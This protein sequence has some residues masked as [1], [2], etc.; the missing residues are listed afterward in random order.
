MNSS[1]NAR[2]LFAT[3]IAA[4]TAFAQLGT[5]TTEQRLHLTQTWK[6]E[7]FED[8]RPKVPDSILKRMKQVTAEEAWSVLNSA[9]FRDHF[10]RGWETVNDSED[11]LVGRVVTA[12]FLPV[13]PDVNAVINETAAQEGRVSKGQ[14][15]W[16]IDTLVPGDVLVVDL[17]GKYNFM[18]DNLATA[19]FTKSKNGVIINGGARDLSGIREIEGFNAYVRGWHPS[20][21]T[22]GVRN[23]MLMGI[24]VPIRIGET[25]VMPGDIVLSDPEGL[26]FIPPQLAE[27]VVTTSEDIRLR[28][29]WGHQMLREGKYTPGQ[30][31]TKWTRQMEEEFRRWADSR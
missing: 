26:M 18:G 5:F 24:N 8:G 1:Q 3:L 31:D 11:R 21:V 14:N 6:G 13:R 23:T 10:E 28:D 25:T 30:I 12:V 22:H 15:S 29:Q 16:V 7:R 20:S 17:Y 9:G 27:R 2:L 4:A 19:I